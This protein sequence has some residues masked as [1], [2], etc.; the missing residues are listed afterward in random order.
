[1]KF[2]VSFDILHKFYFSFLDVGD[3]IS[4]VINRVANKPEFL[5]NLSSADRQRSSNRKIESPKNKNN[6]L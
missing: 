6:D 5:K 2:T 3:T 1:M 4:V